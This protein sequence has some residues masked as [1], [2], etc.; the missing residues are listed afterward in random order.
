MVHIKT[1]VIGD[2]HGCYTEL[3]DLITSLETDGKYNKD[4]DKLIFLGDYIDRG[5]NSK[6]VIEFIRNLQKDNNNVIALMGNHEDMILDY[7][8]GIDNCWTYNGHTETLKS[9]EGFNEQLIE[10]IEWIR[11]LPLYH[12]DEHFIYV[13]AGIDVDKTMQE[14]NK[15]TLLWIREPFIMNKKKYSKRVVFGH[16]PTIGI[17]GSDLPMYTDTNNIGID[18]GCVYGGALTALI[19]EN[20]EASEFYQSY[21]E[22]E[23][24][25]ME[26]KESV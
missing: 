7:F 6:L 2:I 16:T 13:H 24:G 23:L 21:I 22:E 4:T 14:Q 9:Y 3:K 18:T 11:N 19:I 8:Y 20:G 5:D 1:I 26:E 17:N 15:N 25:Y 10:D 12:E